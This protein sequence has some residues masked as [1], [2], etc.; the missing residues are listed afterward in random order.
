MGQKVGQMALRGITA[1]SIVG[2]N[3]LRLG[4]EYKT[5]EEPLRTVRKVKKKTIQNWGI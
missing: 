3:D 5:K 1:A 4:G 2:C